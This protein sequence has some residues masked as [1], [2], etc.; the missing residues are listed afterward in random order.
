MLPL[1]IAH[2]WPLLS[3]TRICE[4]GKLRGYFDARGLPNIEC[5]LPD[6]RSPL[7]DLHVGGYFVTKVEQK[8]AKNLHKSPCFIILQPTQCICMNWGW[9]NDYDYDSEADGT[10]IWYAVSGDWNPTEERNYNISRKAITEY[11]PL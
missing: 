5:R 1:G 7:P 2:K 11:T 10:P 4:N 8:L 9:G 3:L 6:F